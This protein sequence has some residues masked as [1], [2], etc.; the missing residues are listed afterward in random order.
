[1]LVLLIAKQPL[2]W[3][4]SSTLQLKNRFH[5]ILSLTSH[6]FA[7]GIRLHTWQKETDILRAAPGLLTH[8]AVWTWAASPTGVVLAVQA[9]APVSLLLL[10]SQGRR[11]SHEGGRREQL[12][13]RDSNGTSREGE[14]THFQGFRMK[15]LQVLSVPAV[16]LSRQTGGAPV[17]SSR[18]QPPSLTGCR[19]AE[20]QAQRSTLPRGGRCQGQSWPQGKAGTWTLRGNCTSV[21]NKPFWVL[22]ESWPQYFLPH[23]NK[24]PI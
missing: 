16:F 3:A 13:G 9:P 7:V 10:V 17:P 23:K 14:L 18:P 21:A 19:R 12:S 1:M 20:G 15:T 6:N 24:I 5:S 11:H 2:T 4:E 8:R 22:Q